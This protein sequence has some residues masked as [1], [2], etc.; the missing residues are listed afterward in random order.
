MR[1]GESTPLPTG[2]DWNSDSNEFE[3]VDDQDQ[4]VFQEIFVTPNFVWIRGAVQ[5][6]NEVF[7]TKDT[8]EFWNEPHGVFNV[9]DIGLDTKFEY[10]ASKWP[11]VKLPR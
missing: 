5:Y 1:E 6:G 2:W 7:M 3:I 10:P 4:P 8:G 11:G 9:T